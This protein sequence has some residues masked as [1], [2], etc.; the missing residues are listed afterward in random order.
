ME[1]TEYDLSC[2]VCETGLT[3]IVYDCDE[4][5]TYCPMCGSP[6]GDEWEKDV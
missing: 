4:T 3:L 1:D 6:L 2:P 5:P